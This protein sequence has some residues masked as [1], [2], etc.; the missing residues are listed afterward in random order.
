[1][2]NLQIEGLRNLDR[3]EVLDQAGIVPGVNAFDVDPEIV[4]KRLESQPW[5]RRVRVERRLPDTLE[6]AVEERVASAILVDGSSYVLLDSSGEAF[7]TLEPGDPVDR[8]LELP[9]VTGLSR[10]E[11]QSG[12]GQQL[13]VDALEVVR[14]ADSLGLPR[15]SEVHVDPVLG[16]SIVPAE[17]G[18]E[19]RLGKDR[20]AARLQRLRAVLATIEREGRSVDYILIDQEEKLNRVTVGNRAAGMA[21]DESRNQ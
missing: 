18:A 12:A 17:S 1:M 3:E 2:K 20:Y 16:L 19:I 10:P 15:L 13:V 9:L 11:T 14:L 21:N 5:I 6:I 4:Q 8:L 7:K